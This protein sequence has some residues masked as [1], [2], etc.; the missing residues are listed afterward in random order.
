[1]SHPVSIDAIKT[2]L[3]AR[4]DQLVAELYPNA[5]RRG[6][7]YVLGG[8]LGEPGS[9]MSICAR[10][11]K[12]GV[13]QDFAGTAGG[14]VLDLVAAGACHGEVPAAIRWAIDWLGLGGLSQQELARREQKARELKAQ[15]EAQARDDAEKKKRQAKAIWLSGEPYAG[16][17]AERYLLGRA[18]D[19]N[20]LPRLPRVLRYH[21]QVWNAERGH[22]LPAMLA[23][24]NDAVTGEQ[25]A[26]HRTYLAL[27]PDGRVIKADL[28]DP[29]KSLGPGKGGL[30]PLTRGES[31]K[32]LRQ[33]P[34]GEWMGASEGIEN[35]YSAGLARPSL[36]I[37]AAG[38]MGNL[39]ELR[40]P[41]QCGGLFILAD[42]DNNPD[43]LRAF[44]KAMN[45]LCDRRIAFEIIRPPA[46]FKDF[47]DW[48]VALKRQQ[49]G[50]E[51]PPDGFRLINE[52]A[53]CR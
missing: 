22:K 50:E 21:G 33:M 34:D 36:R 38:S 8:V 15:A 13:W 18:I 46:G 41:A 27:Q 30:I 3:C 48:L 2:G 11:A 19:L 47:N 26:V 42:N 45:R 14:D 1:M 9:S 23:P 53:T 10:G 37:C 25:L 49:A 32:P 20:R 17:P 39:G 12:I 40:L 29:K 31:G 5:V 44:E 35:G 7:E 28:I 52:D 51:P 24:F 16:S 6:G 43:A 4:I